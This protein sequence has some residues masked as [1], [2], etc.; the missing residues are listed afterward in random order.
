MS[1]SIKNL[2]GKNEIL[3]NLVNQQTEQNL[4]ADKYIKKQVIKKLSS[5]AI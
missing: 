1:H 2:K 5:I 3:T 4:T